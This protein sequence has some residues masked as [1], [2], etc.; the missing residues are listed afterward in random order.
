M[1]LSLGQIRAV[2]SKQMIQPVGQ[3]VNQIVRASVIGRLLNVLPAGIRPRQ[4]NVI[5]QSKAEYVGVLA[6]SEYVMHAD[7]QYRWFR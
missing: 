5:R 4:S 1:P 3:L 6:S 2:V 7:P